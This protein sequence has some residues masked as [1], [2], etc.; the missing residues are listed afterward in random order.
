MLT[1]DHARVHLFVEVHLFWRI[2]VKRP[3]RPRLLCDG[4]D[5]SSGSSSISEID[6]SAILTNAASSL[7]GASIFPE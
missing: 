6:S 1:K 5:L 7:W 4:L 2:A 3:V